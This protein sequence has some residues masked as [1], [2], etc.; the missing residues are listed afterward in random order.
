MKRGGQYML[1]PNELWGI[2]FECCLDINLE[3]VLQFHWNKA[4]LYRQLCHGF[5]DCY[6]IPKQFSVSID[7]IFCVQTD[8][9]DILQCNSGATRSDRIVI[10]CGLLSWSIF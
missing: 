9:F 8:I 4:L 10:V 6:I 3:Y 1:L 7:T 2:V 5:C